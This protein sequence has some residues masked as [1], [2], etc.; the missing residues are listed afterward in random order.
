VAQ[1]QEAQTPRP[2]RGLSGAVFRLALQP[3]APAFSLRSVADART[4]YCAQKAAVR[5]RVLRAC[6][7][8]VS[9][10]VCSRV[11]AGCVSHRNSVLNQVRVGARQ[12][13]I[14]GPELLQFFM[15][16]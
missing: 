13:D 3:I 4:A 2:G 16:A 1:E 15:R 12:S 9:A 5:C 14:V 10:G 7:L 8:C 6:L 11:Y